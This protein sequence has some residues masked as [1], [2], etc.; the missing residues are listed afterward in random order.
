MNITVYMAS[1]MP[2]EKKFIDSSIELGKYIAN[3]GHTLIYGGSKTGLMGVVADNVLHNNGKVIGVVPDIKLIKNRIHPEL[4]NV[5]YT[6]DM[7]ERRKKMI[8]L[9]DIF[10]ALPGGPGTLDEFSEVMD[11]IRLKSFKKLLLLY[12]VD[13]YYDDI[14]I[15]IEKYHKYGFILEDELD[16]V[17]FVNS[18]DDIKTIID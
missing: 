16:G 2:N 18:L 7:A 3:K 5:I 4:K 1:Y 15:Q 10:I 12:N 17:I 6:S 8:E 9:G 14:K 13:G 11:Y